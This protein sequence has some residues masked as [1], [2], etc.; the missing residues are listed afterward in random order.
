MHT[1]L[2]YQS[3]EY[4][5]AQATLTNA[6]RY[7]FERADI[8]PDLLRA[9]QLYTLDAYNS[10]GERG[11]GGTSV[12]AMQFLADWLNRYGRYKHFPIT[13]RFLRG[14]CL[15]V[16]PDSPI[17]VCLKK[18]GVVIVRCRLGGD[19]HYVLLTQALDGSIGLFDPYEIQGEAAR[20]E[21]AGICSISGVPYKMN[22]IVRLDVLDAEDEGDYALGVRSER[23]AMLLLNSDITPQ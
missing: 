19:A 6:M 10:N 16:A 11:K 12:M 4:D 18:K 15:T 17:T 2:G 23:E 22:R 20:V 13:A 5:C 8:E 14:E 21:R 1:M 7:L 3:S 9:I